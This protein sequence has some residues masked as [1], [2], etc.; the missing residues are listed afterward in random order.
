MK[1]RR[2]DGYA[3][4]ASKHGGK[5]EPRRP[6]GRL[7]RRNPRTPHDRKGGNSRVQRDVSTDVGVGI[8]RDVRATGQGVPDP[9]QRSVH[10]NQP[11]YVV[12]LIAK[13]TKKLIR[14]TSDREGDEEIDS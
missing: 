10:A 6:R 8:H 3:K 5:K 2:V 9:M 13:A 11:K 14:S 1:G 4:A 7:G 12:L